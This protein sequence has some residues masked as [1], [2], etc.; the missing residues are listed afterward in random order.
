LTG[1]LPTAVSMIARAERLLLHATEAVGR[2]DILDA[3]LNVQEA[4]VAAR[5]G[6]AIIKAADEVSKA[7]IDILA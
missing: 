1:T 2:G 6:V 3:A 5:S 7:L 4:K